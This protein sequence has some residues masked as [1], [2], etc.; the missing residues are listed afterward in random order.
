MVKEP[1][2]QS[3]NHRSNR[4]RPVASKRISPKRA[5]SRRIYSAPPKKPNSAL[6]KI[7]KVRLS[8]GFEVIGYIP[9][10]GKDLE[11]HSVVM[12]R[13][14]RVKDLPGVRYHVLRGVIDTPGVKGRKKR[15]SKYKSRVKDPE[16]DQPRFPV[17]RATTDS[18]ARLDS[19]SN[20][21][22]YDLVVPKRTL[23][24]RES[25]NELLTVEE[26]DKALRLDRIA[27]LAEK[28]FGDA[29]KGRRWLRKP[30]QS[31]NGETPLTYLASEVGARVVEEM[32]I[33]VDSGMIP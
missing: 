1:R 4:K 15:R 20:D 7:A 2:G 18:L 19:Y 30:K 11:D 17:V 8:N 14:G 31:L 23:A 5:V 28:V 21:E 22:I 27:K 6:R 25:R 10:E 24:R 3:E 16:S 13:G 9:G 12:I 33:Q 32:L 29:E 26:T